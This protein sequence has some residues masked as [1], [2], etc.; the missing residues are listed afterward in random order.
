MWWILPPERFSQLDVLT[1]RI[2]PLQDWCSGNLWNFCFL[3]C[4][5]KLQHHYYPSQVSLGIR[6]GP[7]VHVSRKYGGWVS[8]HRRLKND[9]FRLVFAAF[10]SA[11]GVSTP[12]ANA[13]T[14]MNVLFKRGAFI[15]TLTPH[16]SRASCRYGEWRWCCQA[17]FLALQWWNHEIG[18]C[19]ELFS[20]FTSQT[21]ILGPFS[22]HRPNNTLLQAWKAVYCSLFWFCALQ[23][24]SAEVRRP[25]FARWRLVPQRD[26]F[27]VS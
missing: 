3:A 5:S 15:F 9:P 4:S 20:I 2:S 11:W 12:D 17:Q 25:C 19:Y 13:E 16:F 8:R 1:C 22:V 6:Q 26:I 18:G 7:F 24:P 21:I 10:F 27:C 23:E 14:D